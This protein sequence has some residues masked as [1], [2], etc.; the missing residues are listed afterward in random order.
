MCGARLYDVALFSTSS[1][2]LRSVP[3]H[4]AQLELQASLRDQRH[5]PRLQ[6]LQC[7]AQLNLYYAQ[8]NIFI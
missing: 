6:I 1:D 3:L 2:R 7:E 4:A 5:V 8:L